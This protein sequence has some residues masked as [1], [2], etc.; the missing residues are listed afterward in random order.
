MPKAVT[1]PHLEG[2]ENVTR[3][4]QSPPEGKRA[5]RGSAERGSFTPPSKAP[6]SPVLPLPLRSGLCQGYHSLTSYNTGPETTRRTCPQ[7]GASCPRP[8]HKAPHT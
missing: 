4:H 2:G 7:P 6:S 5:T 1:A 8:S 3:G